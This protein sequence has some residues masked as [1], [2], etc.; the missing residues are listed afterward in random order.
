MNGLIRVLLADDHPMFLEGVKNALQQFSRIQVIA[1]CTDG[2]AVEAFISTHIVDVAVL[3]I[4]MPG[5]NGLELAKIIHLKYPHTKVVFLTMYHPSA[6]GVEVIFSPHAT[7]YVLKNSGSRILFDAI[8]AAFVGKKFIDPKL[9][10]AIVPQATELLP[11]SV[12]LSSR[13]KEIV[14]LIIEGKANKEI[15]DVLYLSELTIKTHRKNVYHK[16]GVNNV[17]GLLHAVRKS[18]FM[19]D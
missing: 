15:A 17:A 16:L 5:Y 18:G 10:D 3:D 11:S 7:G 12:K 8:A 14:K 19:L 4:N 6:I 2:F 9:Q 1:E 13:E